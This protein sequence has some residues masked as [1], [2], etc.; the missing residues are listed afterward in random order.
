MAKDVKK[1]Q[2]ENIKE[3]KQTSKKGT[4][5]GKEKKVV[6]KEIIKE[7]IVKEEKVKVEEKE[8]TK[9]IKT[10]EQKKNNEAMINVAKKIDE[11]RK[12]ILFGIV[13]FL[14]A[15]LLFRFI[16][17]PDRIATLADGTQ[18]VVNIAGEAY[19]AD[20]LYEDMKEIF[21]INVLLN[22]IDEK[23][24]NEMYPEDEEMTKSVND[25]AEYYYNAYKNY[26]G[27]TKEEFLKSKL[28]GLNT[29]HETTKY[30]LGD[31]VAIATGNYYFCE[32]I[33]END[34][35]FKAHHAGITKEET[36]L[37]V[38]LLKRKDQAEE[39]VEE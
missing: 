19:T 28:S 17:W 23:I 13:G 27:Y 31:Y 22:K 6:K 37:A 21:S 32:Q 25:T 4:N 24:L 38:V 7:E 14:L 9:K 16:L 36:E 5:K 35:V 34:M 33:K 39:E 26:Y 20:Q 12:V 3:K 2:K 1:T 8:V 30:S 11:N 15:T 29:P 18:P 10:K